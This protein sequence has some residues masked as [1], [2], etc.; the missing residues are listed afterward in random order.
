MGVLAL[1]VLTRVAPICADLLAGTDDPHQ[2]AHIS[3]LLVNTWGIHSRD[4]LERQIIDLALDRNTAAAVAWNYPRAVMLAR[5]GHAVG[6]FD[7]DEAWSVIMPAAIV[8]QRSFS[9]WRE[10]GPRVYAGPGRVL[11]PRIVPPPRGRKRLSNDFNGS[12]EPLAQISVGPRSGESRTS[13]HDPG[14]ERGELIPRGARRGLPVC[15][16][17]NSRSF[18]L[19]EPRL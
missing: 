12:S 19:R 17:A 2:L 7:E 10:N 11:G 15:A 5:W 1:A 13:R 16:C 4:E 8:V 9:S 14:E 6:Y 3:D 18:G